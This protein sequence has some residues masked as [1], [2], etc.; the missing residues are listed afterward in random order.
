MAVRF[1]Q[2]KPLVVRV[3]GPW[4]GTVESFT[5]LYNFTREQFRAV[6]NGDD[7]VTAEVYDYLHDT[8]V[9]VKTNQSILEGTR[10]EFYPIDGETL[11]S[12]YDEV[13]ESTHDDA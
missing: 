10:G 11:E 13:V 6:G 9:G 2:K 12:T 7:G 5:E 4:D 1:V 8:W 3:C